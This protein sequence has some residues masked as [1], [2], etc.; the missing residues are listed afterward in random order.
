MTGH[1]VV[2]KPGE[3]QAFWVLGGLYEVKAASDETGAI[4]IMETTMPAGMGPSPRS[5]AGGWCRL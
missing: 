5:L 1:T 4:T 2:R 3:G